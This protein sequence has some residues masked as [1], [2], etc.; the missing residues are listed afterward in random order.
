MGSNSARERE[1]VGEETLDSN[2]GVD[3]NRG[4]SRSTA[5]KQEEPGTVA[6]RVSYTP[7]PDREALGQRYGIEVGKREAGRLQRL[8]VEFGSERVGRWAGE[9]MPVTAMGKPRDLQSFRAQR[10]DGPDVAVQRNE[11]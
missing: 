5:D 3:G 1:P 10:S 2:T 8:E 11:R 4:V 7:G 6:G 9:G